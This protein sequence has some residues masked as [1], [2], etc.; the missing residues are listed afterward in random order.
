MNQ[1]LE[2]KR[3][4]SGNCKGVV[5]GL[6]AYDGAGRIGLDERAGQGRK[7]KK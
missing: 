4:N 2:S 1:S 3:N 5:V 6:L 7:Y